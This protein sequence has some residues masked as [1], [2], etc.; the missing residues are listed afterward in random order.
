MMCIFSK[1]KGERIV[2]SEI[3]IGCSGSSELECGED[4][5]EGNRVNRRG[6]FLQN[7]NIRGSPSTSDNWQPCFNSISEEY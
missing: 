6:V 4:N 3:G 5:L 7:Q 1:K 2:R